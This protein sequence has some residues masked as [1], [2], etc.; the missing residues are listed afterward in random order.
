MQ[1]LSFAWHPC[2]GFRATDTPQ[3]GTVQRDVVAV[4]LSPCHTHP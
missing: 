3:I 4:Y 2:E 1:T